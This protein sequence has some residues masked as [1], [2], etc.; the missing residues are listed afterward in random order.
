M[1]KGERKAKREQVTIIAKLLQ[2]DEK[3]LLS[4]WLADQVIEVL[5]NE[6]KLAGDVLD[7]A[8]ENF[9]K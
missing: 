1:E 3:E 5:K 4:F 9:K 8:K 6:E 2:T 7:I